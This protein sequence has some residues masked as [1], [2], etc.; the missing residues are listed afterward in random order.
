MS[1][2]KTREVRTVEEATKPDFYVTACQVCRKL[3]KNETL[4]DHGGMCYGCFKGYCGG[5]NQNRIGLKH[6]APRG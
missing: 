1:F 2:V 3:T 6:G 5:A 4:S